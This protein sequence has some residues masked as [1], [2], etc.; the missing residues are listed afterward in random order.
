[1][2]IN[3][4]RPIHIYVVPLSTQYQLYVAA[5]LIDWFTYCMCPHEYKNSDK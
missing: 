5:W 4:V 3:N 2:S 1:M